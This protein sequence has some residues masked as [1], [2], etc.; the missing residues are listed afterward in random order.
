MSR[1]TGCCLLLWSAFCVAFVAAA[2]PE[3]APQGKDQAVNWP[4][5]RGPHR[6][7]ISVEQG[8]LQSWSDDGPPLAWKT[9][10]LG[11]GYASISIADGRIFTMGERD[12]AEFVL[13]LD[14]SDG[15]ELWATEVGGPF[16]AS[17]KGP[18]STPTIDG[19]LVYAIGPLG[20]LVCL[21]TATGKVVWRTNFIKDLGGRRP[22][23]GYCESPLV[24]GDKLICTPC[25]SEATMVAFNKSTGDVL[26]KCAVPGIG[27]G[28]G[29]SSIVISEACGVKQYVQLLG[30][31]CG[32]VGVQAA[33]GKL[34]WG[35]G[36]V[37]NG[38][39]SIP[40]P[41]V[42]GDHVF[43]SSGYGTGAAL[44]QL[45]K[46]GEEIKA[47]EVYFLDG[48]TFQ[49]HHGGMILI[50]EHIYAGSGH[51]NGFPVC[52]EMKSGEIV[53]GGRQRG[54]GSGSAAIVFADGELYFRYQ[55][56]TM[57]LIK[58]TPE[59][60]KLEGKFKIPEVRNPSWAHPVVVG[61]KLYLREQDNLF[62]YDVASPRS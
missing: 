39:A 40:T 1:L 45:E 53:W 31:G 28:A 2:E 48:K 49:N 26:W 44:L 42:Q 9:S 27:R 7:G 46:A 22:G 34:L 33:N 13:A 30:A 57:A 16:E 10:G 52:L 32:C 60:Y 50:G 38:T 24:D 47:N 36:R 6:D 14:S 61:G 41:I 23:W 8:L 3:K 11:S 12:G 43:C 55:D 56:G 20:D 19:A 59:E 58:A 4:Q 5:W 29:Y 51:N 37:G 18:R 21:E 15:K 35:Y 54:P 17:G 62:V 25:G